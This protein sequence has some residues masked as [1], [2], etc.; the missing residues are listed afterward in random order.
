MNIAENTKSTLSE[1]KKFLVPDL[2]KK[3]IITEK[4][5]VAKDFSKVLNVQSTRRTDGY[6]ENDSYIITWCVGHLVQMLYPDA[7]D[8]KYAKWELSTLPFLPDEYIYGVIPNVEKQ[9]KVVE[10]CLHRED[11]ETVYWAGDSG[12]EGQT[13]EENIRHYCGVRKGVKELRI[14]IDSQT[15][16]EI[17]RG[18][19]EAKPMNDYKKI[20]EAGIMRAIE[21][22]AMGINFSRAL[23]K[24]YGKILYSLYNRNIPI[25]VG[26]VMTCVL[27]MVVNRENEIR[28]FKE[29][30]FY[31]VT[32]S[33][34][35]QETSID[36][37][38][39][40]QEES[41]LYNPTD[42]YKDIGFLD[43][44]NA[45]N[46][47]KQLKN[48]P[49]TVK[50][51]EKA[52]NKKNPPL[53]YNLAELQNDCSNI[54]KISPDATLEIAQTLYEKKLTTYPRTDAR[55]LSTAVAKE[56]EKNIKGL[57][58]IPI[59]TPTTQMIL[60]NQ[61]YKDIEKTSYTNDKKITDHYAII[62]TGNTRE[63]S[64]LEEIEKKVFNLIAVRFLSIFLE[65]A[66]YNTLKIT[67]TVD[68]EHFSTSTKVI[69]NS[70]YTELL[71]L[72]NDKTEE[73]DDKNDEL[74][75]FVKSLKEGDTI[76]CKNFH[77]KQGKTTPPKRYNSGSL[78]LA[79]ENA[80]QL[81]E[82]EELRAQIK[83]SGIGTSATRAEILKK[84]TSIEYLNL[85]KKTQVVKPER[86]GEIIYYI[87]RLTIPALLSPKMTA[88]WEKGLELI[89]KGEVTPLEYRAKLYDFVSSKISYV[90]ENDASANIYRII[91]SLSD[92]QDNKKNKKV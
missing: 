79:M 86:I 57:N 30:T 61:L 10:K 40:A 82:D 48:K 49:A 45:T 12:R 35:N 31:K 77:T 36:A 72:I 70:G 90:K 68:N 18:I 27:G 55:V 87:V 32:G 54:L 71:R 17:L 78:I 85:N 11:V 51:I 26:R 21:D 59:Y 56:I 33:F 14:W 37:E 47:I 24:K 16:E 38:W 43:K 84:L 83:G 34:G 15:E 88:S 91:N 67:I 46:F 19:K 28:T 3:L 62:P 5:S 2:R 44:S 76:E 80:G 1:D 75:N 92:E 69:T 60:N 39:K 7:Y 52:Q 13:I 22:Y 58:T 25:A 66:V 23:T 50:L 65:P 63:Y 81:I 74:D 89:Q 73:K 6:I 64:K 20:G 8:P 53:L 9:Y 29:T 42:I 41:S 4:P